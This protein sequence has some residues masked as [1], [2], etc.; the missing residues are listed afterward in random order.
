[1][2]LIEAVEEI[3]KAAILLDGVDQFGQLLT[4]IST[5]LKELD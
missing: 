2:L 1:M 4:N 3:P 5:R